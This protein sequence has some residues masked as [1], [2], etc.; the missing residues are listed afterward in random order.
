MANGGAV[1]DTAPPLD[2]GGRKGRIAYVL[3]M[4]HERRLARGAIH[5]TAWT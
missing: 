2:F 5:V 3:I 4:M 1:P